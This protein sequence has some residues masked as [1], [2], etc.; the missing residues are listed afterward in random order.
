[1]KNQIQKAQRAICTNKQKHTATGSSAQHNVSITQ[2][3]R[4]HTH[5]E[6]VECWCV[7]AKHI[8]SNHDESIRNWMIQTTFKTKKKWVRVRGWRAG[9]PH[10]AFACS[11]MSTGPDWNFKS[12]ARRKKKTMHEWRGEE[13]ELP[14]YSTLHPFPKPFLFNRTFLKAPSFLLGFY[15]LD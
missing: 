12:K 10:Q 11:P 9:I 13:V 6:N 8:P 4:G 1:M 7:T 5:F 15:G 14:L 2:Q 3:L